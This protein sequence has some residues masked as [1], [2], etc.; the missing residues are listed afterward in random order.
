MTVNELDIFS[1]LNMCEFKLS[2]NGKPIFSI[3]TMQRKI[4]AKLK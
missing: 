2:N 3:K 1:I 4:I